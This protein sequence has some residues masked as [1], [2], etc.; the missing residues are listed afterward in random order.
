MCAFE[1]RFSLCRIGIRLGCAFRIKSTSKKCTLYTSKYK[2]RGRKLEELRV[3]SQFFQFP[4]SF[5]VFT[6]IAAIFFLSHSISSSVA[7]IVVAA[8]N[9]TV[10][11]AGCTLKTVGGK[12]PPLTDPWVWKKTGVIFVFLCQHLRHQSKAPASDFVSRTLSWS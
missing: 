4:S 3:G 8:A 9:L 1:L 2:E 11:R 7:C 6:T 10:I 12:Q 5:F